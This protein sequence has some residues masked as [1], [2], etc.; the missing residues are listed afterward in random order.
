MQICVFPIFLV[1]CFSLS[2]FQ[3]WL[4]SYHCL[5]CIAYFPLRL[6]LEG[7]VGRGSEQRSQFLRPY[8]P[9]PTPKST[10][11]RFRLFRS[12]PMIPRETLMI[13]CSR[14]RT[15]SNPPRRYTHYTHCRPP[16]CPN[17]LATLWCR[18]FVRFSSR[19][20]TC[21]YSIWRPRKT[22]SILPSDCTLQIL[23]ASN[24]DPRA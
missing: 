12:R 4:W 19:S 3:S 14:S 13:A 24:V 21:E 1:V 7:F 20:V 6:I 11:A 8:P 17:S 2:T 9:E 15:H 22:C 18:L 5:L 10:V 16:P 23:R